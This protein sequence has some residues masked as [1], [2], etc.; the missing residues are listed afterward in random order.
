M[1]FLIADDEE[2]DRMW[3]KDLLTKHIPEQ[4]PIHEVV[5]G[6]QAVEQAVK[7]KPDFGA[8]LS[9]LL[10]TSYHACRWRQLD[11]LSEGLDWLIRTRSAVDRITVETPLANVT[12]CDDLEVNRIV[13]EAECRRVHTRLPSPRPSFD[14]ATRRRDAGSKIIVGYLSNAFRTHPTAYLMG[15]LFSLHDRSCFTIHAYSTG[16]N[17][18]S[19]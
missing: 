13:A 16:V 3:L 8:A 6:E 1:T 17:D 14:H 15:G 5:N 18:G 9:S 10:H 12:R 4:L 19:R 11:E 2:R 7:L